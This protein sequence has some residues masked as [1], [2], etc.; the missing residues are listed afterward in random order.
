MM[1]LVLKRLFTPGG[2]CQGA[3][4]RVHL[5]RCG[6]DAERIGGQPLIESAQSQIPVR[7]FSTADLMSN[8]L[9][10][11]LGAIP[12]AVLARK[13]TFIRRESRY[14]QQPG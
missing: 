6:R 9:G 11:G 4:R 1:S 10:A 5:R 12:F 8:T 13:D 2:V 3:V 14:V 7:A